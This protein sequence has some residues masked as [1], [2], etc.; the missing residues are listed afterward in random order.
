MYVLYCCSWQFQFNAFQVVQFLLVCTGLQQRD[1]LEVMLC[2]V[3]LLSPWFHTNAEDWGCGVMCVLLSADMLV[4]RLCMVTTSGDI[5]DSSAFNHQSQRRDSASPWLF[6][7]RW[8]CVST[9][10]VDIYLLASGHRHASMTVWGVAWTCTRCGKGEMK[11]TGGRD[12]RAAYC[13][14]I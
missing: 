5:N 6:P 3:G 2:G 8:T 14:V 13:F 12:G 4:I 7:P 1:W 11:D 9:S 10:R